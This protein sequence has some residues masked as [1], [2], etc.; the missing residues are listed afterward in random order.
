MKRPVDITA[1]IHLLPPAE[2]GRS[3]PTFGDRFGCVMVVGGQSHDVRFWLDDPLIPGTTRT[4]SA[5][6][7]S[8]STALAHIQPGMNFALWEGGTIGTGVIEA[9]VAQH[10]LG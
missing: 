3:T 2:G 10:A 9:V 6:F 4:V 7:L 5:G 8:P 1:T